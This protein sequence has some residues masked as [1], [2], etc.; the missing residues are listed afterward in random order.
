MLRLSQIAKRGTSAGI[1]KLATPT[2]QSSASGLFRLG[3]F[4]QF[5]KSKPQA[6]A[7]FNGESAVYAEALYE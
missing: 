5:T 2:V 4:A 3:R 6:K 1:S 7:A